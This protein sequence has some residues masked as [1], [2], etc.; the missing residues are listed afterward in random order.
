[1]V[2]TQS[3]QKPRPEGPGEATGPRNW[4][5]LRLEEQTLDGR[6]TASWD[7]ELSLPS[8]TQTWLEHNLPMA[9]TRQVENQRTTDRW[10]WPTQLIP[11]RRWQAPR[12]NQCVITEK[13]G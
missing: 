3:A 10:I 6:D 12:E 7:E 8:S 4:I 9:R 13:L 11:H 1:M 2:D 5:N